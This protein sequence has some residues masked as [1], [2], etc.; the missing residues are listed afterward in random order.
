MGE[1]YKAKD[2][3]LERVVAVKILPGHLPPSHETRQR[4]EREAKTISQLSHPHIC[5]LYDVGNQDGVEY[6]VMEYLEGETLADRLARGPLPLEQAIRFGVEIADALGRAHRQ[7]IVHRDLKPGN[8]MLTKS[9]VKLL[10][11][12]LAKA[13]ASGG[14]PSGLTALPTVAGR[15]NLTQ[16][17]TILGT[18]QYMAPEQLEGRESDGRAD[19][20]ALGAVFYEMATGQKAFMGSSQASLTSAILRDEPK[21][22]SQAQ[23][24][25]PP[26]LDHVVKTCLAKDPEDRWQSAHDVA[27]ELKWIA[28]EGSQAGVPAPVLSRRKSRERLA[29][30][31]AAVFL[32]AAAAF[33]LL[34]ARVRQEKPHPSPIHAL[35]RVPEKAPFDIVAV[36][37]LSPDGKSIVWSGSDAGS[38]QTPPLWVRSLSSDDAHPLAGTERAMYAFWSPDS[39]SIGFFA[40]HKMKRVDLAGGAPVTLCDIADV[41]RGGAWSPQGVIIFSGARAGPLYRISA[42]GGSPEPLTNL[43]SKRG[44]TTHRW[45]QFLPDGRHFLYLASPNVSE[46]RAVFVAS[47][48]G[49]ENRP[50]PL[51]PDLP[52]PASESGHP[53]RTEAIANAAYASGHIL[54]V[55]KS[56]LYA[57][58][59]DAAK[60]QVKGPAVVVAENVGS[61]YSVIRSMF[62]VSQNDELIYVEEPSDF[63]SRVEW[64]DR[65]GRLSPALSESAIYSDVQFSPNGKQ[66]ALSI[67]DRRTRQTDIWTIDLTRDVRTRLTF[68]PGQSASPVWSPDASRVI[69]DASRSKIGIFE[70]A[71]SG[72]GPEKVLIETEGEATP[73][74]WSSDGR[75]VLYGFWNRTEGTNYDVW[76]LPV[77]PLGKPF[78]YLRATA[79][80]AEA[81]FS[82]D[83][84]HVA[85]SST[86][87]GRPEIYVQSFPAG[88]GKWQISTQGGSSPRWRKDGRELFF[89]GDD[90]RIY[91]VPVRGDESFE[92]GTPRPAF[93]SGVKVSGYDVA[94][95]GQRFI[96]WTPVVDQAHLP[97]RLVVH[98]PAFIKR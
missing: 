58:P 92:A 77:S 46:K 30:I 61:G 44:D 87:S 88:A 96:K 37:E 8:V 91:A 94:P 93:E 72:V 7:G 15:P 84:K 83:G 47:L 53:S 69:Y 95:D 68:G 21:P 22:I 18:L 9:G 2:T 24:M 1:V 35:V 74:S 75:F 10:D 5:S 19:I 89:L 31:A 43:D 17:G 6:L 81:C 57:R 73:T 20:F 13:V 39:R 52:L 14:P 25:T 64:I 82:P 78:P 11:F 79:D 27:S 90:G 41:G 62:S 55:Q 48:D 98:W 80:E 42:T 66:L 36:P 63:D 86:E 51:A 38:L 29:W 70:K 34:F 97:Q 4:F 40:D 3:R 32:V 65:Q 23:P 28:E 60:A 45:P 76:V 54:F 50:L 56:T 26:A 49:H 12:G 33:A 85:Y 67:E 59:F 71:S 16:E